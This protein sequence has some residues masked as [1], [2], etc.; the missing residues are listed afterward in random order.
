MTTSNNNYIGLRNFLKSSY[1]IYYFKN[2]IINAIL[3]I[4]RARGSRELYR[5]TN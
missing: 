4:L 5:Y 3:L 2:I 1:Y